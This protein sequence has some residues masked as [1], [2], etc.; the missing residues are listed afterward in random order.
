[1]WV[2]FLG[3]EDPLEEGMATRSSI[4]AWRVPWTEQPEGLVHGVIKSRTRL[5]QQHNWELT[6]Q[7]QCQRLQ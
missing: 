1:M 2:Q 7:C 3:W 6:T 5:K 4:L